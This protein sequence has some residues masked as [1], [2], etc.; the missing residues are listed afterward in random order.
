MSVQHGILGRTKEI[1][2]ILLTFES[3]MM[4]GHLS[5]EDLL[6]TALRFTSYY[7][8]STCVFIHGWDYFSTVYLGWAA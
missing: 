8:M 3:P 2:D 6:E 4:S 7:K 5:D 1:S